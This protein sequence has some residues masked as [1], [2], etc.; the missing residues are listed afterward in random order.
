MWPTNTT[1]NSEQQ[2]KV[3]KRGKGKKSSLKLNGEELEEVPA[4]KYL[5]EILNNKGKLS[6]HIAEIERKIKGATA[7]VISETGNKEF[8]GIK[9]QAIW[10]M[11]DAIIIPIMTYACKGWMIGKEEKKT[12]NHIQWSNKNSPIPPKGHPNNDPAQWNRVHASRIYYNEK[13]NHASKKNRHDEGRS[14][15]IK[16]ATQPETSTWRKHIE[17]IAKELNVYEQMTILSKEALKTQIVKEVESKI[18]VELENEAKQKTKVGHWRQWKK[19]IKIGIRP[20]YMDKL[21]RKQC[22]AI[23]RTRASMMMVKANYKTEYGPNLSYRLWEQQKETQQHILQDCL[24]KERPRGKIEYSRIFEEDP[25]TPK[26]LSES[27]IEIEERLRNLSLHSMSSS[28]RSE[29]PGW[30]GHMQYYYYYSAC[31]YIPWLFHS[32][33]CFTVSTLCAYTDIGSRG[34]SGI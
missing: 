11:V 2:K 26:T 3:I 30:P 8:K 25:N 18:Q 7:S 4:Y 34:Y 15:K 1:Y 28:N 31:T 6:D 12:T 14:P 13:E 16:D 22:N 29:P 20:K 21:S 19:E 27:I 24:R 17:D 23:I 5:G 32:P 10:Q 9:M 33:D